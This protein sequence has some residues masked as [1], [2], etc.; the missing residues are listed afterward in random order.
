MTIKGF[1]R[2]ERRPMALDHPKNQEGLVKPLW[3]P[4]AVGTGR[5]GCGTP[6]IHS[7]D[8]GGGMA[9]FVGI[10]AFYLVRLGGDWRA[11]WSRRKGG[12][13]AGMGQRELAQTRR[14]PPPPHT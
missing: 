10:E 6:R 3:R 13:G 11:R 9:R 12:G 14:H 2:G 8:F 1:L 4:G 7:G 5:H